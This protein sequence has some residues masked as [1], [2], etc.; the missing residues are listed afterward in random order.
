MFSN[1]L[2]VSDYSERFQM[3]HWSFLGLGD[4]ENCYGTHNYKLEG[5]WISIADVMY[6]ISKT[7]DIQGSAQQVRWIEDS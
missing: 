3:G 1:Y 6:P 2:K 7:T 4:E 5:Q